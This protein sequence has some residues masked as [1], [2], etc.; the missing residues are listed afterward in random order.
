MF[1]Y[2][3]IYTSLVWTKSTKE[4]LLIAYSADASYAINNT[5]LVDLC[6]SRIVASYHLLSSIYCTAT[7]IW[8]NDIIF[9][10]L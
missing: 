7:Y 3:M 1:V 2:H 10:A 9:F 6:L 8:L 4:V 5:S